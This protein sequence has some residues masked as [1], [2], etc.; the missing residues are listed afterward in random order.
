[1]ILTGA[2]L[3]VDLPWPPRVLH[4][5][6]RPHWAQRARAAKKARTQA[7]W[8]AR[9]AGIR[10][11][12]SQDLRVTAVFTPPDRRARDDDGMLSNIK[13]YL[14]GISDVIGV[15]DSKWK[16]AMRR[17]P[18]RKPGSVRIEIEEVRE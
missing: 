10:R 7:A 15:D 2:A 4:P 11:L 5:N 8:A 1:M 13:S 9:A 3:Y 14:D 17:E 12:D 6:E 18:A 16:L